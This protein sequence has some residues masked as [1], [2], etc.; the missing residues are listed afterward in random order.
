MIVMGR[1][2]HCPAVGTH[3]RSGYACG[4]PGAPGE[5][6][7]ELIK[8]GV[9]GAFSGAVQAL[10][11]PIS[12]F[13]GKLFGPGAEQLGGWAGDVIAYRRWQTRVKIM[14][15]AQALLDAAGLEAHEV[16][17]P[18]LMPILEAAGDEEDQ[19]MADRWA[20][21]LANAASGVPEQVPPR[22][23]A[24]LRELSSDEAQLLDAMYDKTSIRTLDLAN[25][26][27]LGSRWPVVFDGLVANR[28][29][30]HPYKAGPVASEDRTLLGLT[31][32]GRAFVAACRPPE[33]SAD[34]E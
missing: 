20:A 21:L 10:V 31:A 14:L 27:G 16:P 12:G 19:S 2:R 29:A 25:E 30:V 34:V 23:P 15:K 13:L 26:L 11:E 9:E 8:A 22:F 33:A 32:L 7:A 28:L 1:S 24:I 6:P 17:R 3:R 4:V 18:V 5:D